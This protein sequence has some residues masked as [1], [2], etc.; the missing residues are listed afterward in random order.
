MT[1]GTRQPLDADLA[2]VADALRRVTV[3]VRGRDWG[4][5]SGLVWRPDGLIVTNAHVARDPRPQVVLPDGQAIEGKL[6]A[7]DP[8]RDLALLTIP[9]IGLSA[10]TP[11]EVASLRVG[12]LVLAFGH[13]LGVA[14]ALSLGVIHAIGGGASSRWIRADIRLAPGNS[15][16]P[17]ADAAGRVIGINT[18]IA[19]GLAYAVPVTAIER[20][21]RKAA[22]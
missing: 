5:G 1:A 4:E 2:A 7:A 9:A 18:L 6:V 12:E 10:A 19:G 22:A 13:P 20:F 8:E 17:L 15:G 14:N 3:R 11:R 21:L 16:G